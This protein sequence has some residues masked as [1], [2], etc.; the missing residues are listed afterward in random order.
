MV[1]HFFSMRHMLRQMN[2]S[3]IVL[4]PKTKN[5]LMLENFRPISLCNVS[6]KIITK[7]LASRRPRLRG[8]LAKLV[9]NPQAAFILECAI[10]DDVIVA[11]EIFH[12]MEH[13]RGKGG[14]V[15]VKIDMARPMIDSSRDLFCQY[16]NVSALAIHGY[17]GLKS[18]FPLSHFLLC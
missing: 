10:H 14:L 9:L 6:Y 8:V 2:H 5:P 15:A 18:V 7:I 3:F 11:H 12:T 13:K 1:Q 16:F 4:I 17:S